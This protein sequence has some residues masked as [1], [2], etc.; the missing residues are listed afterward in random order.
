MDTHQIIRQFAP[1]AAI[2]HHIPG[3]IRIRLDLSLAE[4]S[5]LREFD[6]ERLRGAL[7]T[8]RGVRDVRINGL[9]RSCTVEYDAGVIPSAAWEDLLADRDTPAAKV[10]LDI[11]R[12][13]H[14]TLP[15]KTAF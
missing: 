13:R 11:L 8:I 7:T 3:R 14:E 9:A 1:R 15:Q 4:I 12:E 10:L 6:P 5:R 2:A